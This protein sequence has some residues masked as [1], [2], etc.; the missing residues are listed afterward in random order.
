MLS[1]MLPAD[2]FDRTWDDYERFAR[3]FDRRTYWTQV[4]LVVGLILSGMISV[5]VLAVG[6]MATIRAFT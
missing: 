5:S 6:V 4:G 2:Y 3:T 1:V